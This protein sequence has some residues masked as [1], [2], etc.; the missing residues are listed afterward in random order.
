MTRYPL[1]APNPP[2]LSEQ[3]E[4]LRRIEA[5]GVFSNNGAEVRAFERDVTDRLFG[6]HGASLAVANATLGLMIAIKQAAQQV[7]R[8]DGL[9]LMPSLT[10]AATGQAALWS[11]LTP[12]ICDVDPDD[13]SACRH[14]EERLLETRGDRISVLVPYATFGNAIDLDRYCWLQRKY[15]VGVVI[16]A[17]SSLGTVDDAG[18][19]FG[20]DSPFAT[21]Y[22]MHATKTFAVAEG[23]LVHSGDAGLIDQLRAMTNFGFE[24][25]RSATLYGINAKLPEVVAVLAQ[26]KLEQIDAVC[27]ARAELE[28]A[29][30]EGLSGFQLQKVDGRR[31]AMQFMPVLLPAALAA[32]RDA[33]TAA[34]DAAGVGTGRY[35]SPHLA[36]QPLF[37]T[38][39]LIEPTP[40]AD[41]VAARMISLPITDAMTAA[42]ATAVAAIFKRVCAEASASVPATVRTRPVARTL[43]IGGG[44]AGTALLTAATKRGQLG[45]FA[46][47]LVVV[48]RDAAIGVGRLGKYAITSDSTATTFLT[49][50]KDNPYPEIAAILDHPAGRAVARYTD[51]IGVPL[52]EAGPL[53]RATG[54]RLGDIVSANGGELLTGHEAL[55][56]RRIDGGMWSTRLRRRADGSEFEQ[57]SHNVVIATGGH[58]PLDRLAAQQVAGQSLVAQ[59]GD[60]LLQSDEV[61]AHG[62]MAKVADLLSG[63]RAPKIVVIGGSTSALATI[64]LILKTAPALPFGEHG[65]TLLHRRPLRPFYPSIEAAQAEGFTDFTPDDI[66][67]VSGFVYRLAGFRLEARE[68][69]LRMLGVDGRVADPRIRNHRITGDDDAVAR[70][71]LAEA[72]I[73]IAALGYRPHALP[74]FDTDGQPIDLS[75]A[76]NRAMVDKHCRVTDAGGA[77]IPGLYGIGL[78]AGFV[79]WGHLGGEAS[80]SGQANGLWQWQ[81]DVGQMIVDQVLG[82]AAERRAVA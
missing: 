27:D 55:G 70:S 56:T 77:A 14:A 22:S 7:G 50:V 30:R 16:D 67:P 49:A 54:D 19:G 57:L 59:A 21:V 52:V 8:P 66:C 31:R 45:D 44:P 20:H 79:P 61:L 80:F 74:V 3:T 62:G 43:L 9:A 81:N 63:K 28:V 53:I 24:G 11:G 42:D 68:L 37:K 13:W 51:A 2:R 33:I 29:Y 18:N 40:I 39:A 71:A 58:Q 78:A 36:E 46:Q 6:G 38:H 75:A 4:A 5:S 1:I 26:A 41:T 12:L 35:F 15:G 82:V 48:E 64:F 10:F 47:G 65:I 34:M 32:K 73:V 23:G 76:H 17:A 72:D 25:S 60:R 69:V